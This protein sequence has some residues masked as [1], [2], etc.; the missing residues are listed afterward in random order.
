MKPCT[1]QE[2]VR[3]AI[4][5]KILRGEW[6]RGMMIP[7]RIQL[8]REFGVAKRTM[9]LAVQRLIAEGILIGEKRRG[10]FVAQDLP[11]SF[12]ARD[13]AKPEDQQT[14]V[15]KLVAIF[16]SVGP[17]WTPERY[18]TSG[19]YWPMIVSG[20][21]EQ[22]LS[23]SGCFA[24]FIPVKDDQDLATMVEEQL[25]NDVMGLAFIN[26]HESSRF[27][28][29]LL[30]LVPRL[31][32]PTIYVNNHELDAPVSHLFCGEWLAGHLA[33]NHLID[34]G[35]SRIVFVDMFDA[36]WNA[37]RLDGARAAA[38]A[39]S[40]DF[41]V[42]DGERL[43]RG[44]SPELED[45]RKCAMRNTAHYLMRH[46]NPEPG[47]DALLYG[48][49]LAALAGMDCLCDAGCE[50]GVCV[51]VMGF[52]DHW[53]AREK[54]LSTMRP[55]LET[56]GRAAAEHLLNCLKTPQPLVQIRMQAQ[57]IARLSTRC[58]LKETATIR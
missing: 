30:D 52:D 3:Q 22:R 58:Q 25:E 1:I 14:E 38:Q 9:E 4:L 26:I 40:V 36:R 55:P 10:T 45:I 41:I 7:G 13:E 6:K 57:V 48:N 16:C 19:Q 56:I 21:M 27:E 50:P 12:F 49:D 28:T 29:M 15:G 44:H 46:P 11:S 51:G 2:Q 8:A 17:R 37:A 23:H 35:Y 43:P 34:A 33:A 18:R 24:Q 31:K 42:Q 20:A 47:H 39:R 5:N 53:Q 54:G 32:V